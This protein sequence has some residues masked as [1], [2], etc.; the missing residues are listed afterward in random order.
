MPYFFE[1]GDKMAFLDKVFRKSDDVDVEEF[2]NNLDVEEESVYDDADAFVKPIN[3]TKDQDA[4]VVKAELKQGNI[5]LLGIGDLSKRNQIKLKELLESVKGAVAEIDGDIA[6]ISQDRL[7][8]TPSK[9]KIIKQ[10]A[11]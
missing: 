4:E 11:Q 3:L 1:R 10:R 2:L 5:V 8:V 9:V 6:R 7:L